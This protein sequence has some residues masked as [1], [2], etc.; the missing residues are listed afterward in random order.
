MKAV[1]KKESYE[2]TEDELTYLRMR[3][4]VQGSKVQRFF[5]GEA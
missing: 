2:M 3:S 1:L 4:R 5:F